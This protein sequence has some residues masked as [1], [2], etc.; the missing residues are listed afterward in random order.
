ML[1]PYFSEGIRPQ[2][3]LPSSHRTGTTPHSSGGG[4]PLLL[5]I[6]AATSAAV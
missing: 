6:S 5:A 1:P 2:L 3:S 4:G